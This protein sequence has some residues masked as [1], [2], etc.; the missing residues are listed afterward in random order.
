MSSNVDI[1]FMR[2]VNTLLEKRSKFDAMPDSQKAAFR[3]HLTR[4]LNDMQEANAPAEVMEALTMLKQEI[5]EP[6]NGRNRVS[7]DDV[8]KEF[9]TYGSYNSRQK[10]AYKS[11]VTR[12][13]NEAMDNGN[14]EAQKMLLK[15]QSKIAEFEAREEM[16]QFSK[17]LHMQK[18]IP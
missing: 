6:D 13:L 18:R 10:G 14:E 5:G 2:S 11:K 8:V 1:S 9:A 4:L 12:F 17:L 3:S 16:E 7:L 15:L